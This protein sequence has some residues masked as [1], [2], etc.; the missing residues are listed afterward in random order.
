MLARNV[1]KLPHPYLTLGPL[2][3]YGVCMDKLWFEQPWTCGHNDP[4]YKNR[5]MQE[6]AICGL[7]RGDP[8]YFIP[9]QPPAGTWASVARMMAAGDDPTDGMPRFDWDAWKDQMK[10]GEL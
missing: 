1:R 8:E 4:I 2:D 7:L 6:C 10:D 5:D 9:A 3:A